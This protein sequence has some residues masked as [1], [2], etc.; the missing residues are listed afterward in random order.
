MPP[1]EV[2]PAYEV[3]KKLIYIFSLSP[4]YEVGLTKYALLRW[5]LRSMQQQD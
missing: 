5:C 4:A 3:E 2:G 1:Y